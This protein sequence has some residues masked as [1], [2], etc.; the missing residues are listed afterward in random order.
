MDMHNA[1]E[2]I[3]YLSTEIERHN[4]LYY[5]S[6]KPEI[7]DRDFD[8]LLEELIRIESEYPQLKSPDSPSQRVGGE[9]TK[10][11]KQVVHKYPMLSL[12][13]TYSEQEVREFD[14]RIIKSIGGDTEYVCELKFDGVA[15]GL[16]YVNGHLKTAVT[17]GDGIQG[18]DIT[19]NVKTIRSIP[20]VLPPGD[21]PAE[22]EIRGEIYMSRESFDRINAETAKQLRE[23]GYNEDEISDR[24]LKNPRNAAAG[25]IKM[26][27][28]KVVASRGLDCWLY[29]LNGENL[30]FKTHYESLRKAKDWG[31]K[32]SDYMVKA[33]G[34]D[35]IID[36][37][38]EWD[39]AR[40]T[41]GYD[42]D[43]VVIK[44]ND[45]AK[46]AE[47]GFT[48][49]SPRW[50]I[51][52][53]FKPE[54]VS[55]ALLSISYQVGRTG[56]ITPVANLNPVQLSGTTVRR[57]SLHNADQIEKLG[58]CVGDHVFV[59]KGG[60]IIPKV[61]GIDL[62]KRVLGAAP[63]KYIT[64]CPECDT[65]L[66]RKEGEALHYCPNET[67]CPPQIKGKLVH[68]IGRRAMDIDS[69]GEEKIE[70]LYD[71]GLVKTP[72]DLFELTENDLLGLERSM[73]D[74]VGKGKKISLREKSVEKILSGIS[75]SKKTH[76]ERVLY[77]IGIR[78][79]GE[80]V[81][82]KL[83]KH[84]KNIDNLSHATFDQ[85]LEAPE[86]GEKIAGSILS[87]FKDP[88][89]LELINRLK[90]QGLCFET[91]EDLN[92]APVS[93]LLSGKSFV[94][95]GVF[96]G[97]SRDK[98]KQVIES[99]GGKIQSGVS[100]KTDYLVAGAE[101]GPSKLEK[102]QSLG[103]QIITET[104]LINMIENG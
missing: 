69:I 2:R 84:F 32:V 52:Y 26:Q 93:S 48:A 82:K 68:F 75:K 92:H 18:D 39:Q 20:L 35:D 3:K 74:E 70:L 91:A 27:D 71:K 7:S 95:S 37:L 10:E 44:V 50:A 66:V 15:V 98:L 16:T 21:Y 65:T 57:A 54:N 1:Q 34:L 8:L 5:V 64:N 25:T 53:K 79:V 61:T 80:T 60:E 12:S 38:N 76:F 85:L 17:R 43:G 103:I 97:F 89:S 102:A 40:H 59:E 67:G 19:A 56:A 31:F 42:T 41:L 6:A 83:A 101:S 100:S 88:I 28:S 62:N 14:E 104:E 45:I 23:D 78:Y 72:A 24:L 51:A 4:R 55:T 81:A 22:F 99:H 47:L 86:V 30:P 94:V 49:K 36:Y 58:I 13:N 90:N 77:A 46:Q 87:F 29:F 9:I 33:N 11:F 63:V 96:E 73:G